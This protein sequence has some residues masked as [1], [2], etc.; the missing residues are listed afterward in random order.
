[1]AIYFFQEDLS[2]ELPKKLKT[3]QWLN[4]IARGEGFQIRNL[5]F[6]FCSD[7]YLYHI[8]SEYL[9][10]HTYTDIIT[11]DHRET[12]KHLEG[13]IYISIE[14]VK[15]NANHQKENFLTEVKRVMS[16]GLFHLCGYGDKST[17]EKKTMRAKE[18][19]ALETFQA[20]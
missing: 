4:K 9:S 13:D 20:L 10:H 1:M 2:F 5:N 7:E 8:N 18:A 12:E 14:R 15:E 6:I 17:S 19:Q 3:K 16:H 11:F